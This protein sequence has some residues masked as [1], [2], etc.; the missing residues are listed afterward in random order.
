MRWNARRCAR[1]MAVMPSSAACNQADDEA[2][3]PSA[4]WDAAL[5]GGVDA[6][7]APP[8]PGGGALPGATGSGGPA[9]TSLG[10]LA[11]GATAGANGAMPV[12]TGR[13]VMARNYVE[14]CR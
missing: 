6:G 9:G 7:A 12:T 2:P 8:A 5:L 4:S 13:G 10:G 11:G 3:G 14:V 1:L